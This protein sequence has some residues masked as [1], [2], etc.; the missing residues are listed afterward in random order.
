[1]YRALIVF[2]NYDLITELQ[3][4]PV[5]GAAT[6]FEINAV[7]RDGNS[8]YM[9]LR[10]SPYD[11]VIAEICLPN[12]DGLQ[13]LKKLT[14]EKLCSH[15]VLCSEYPNFDYARQGIIIGAF[16]YLV[17]PFKSELMLSLFNR[18]KNETYTNL[19]VEIYQS[20]EILEHFRGRNNELYTYLDKMLN[21]IYHENG[22]IVN[23][24]KMVRHIYDSVIDGLYE[25][26]EWMDLYVDQQSFYA[27][28]GIF[29]GDHSTY[30]R[31]YENKILKLFELYCELFP[32]VNNTQLEE[33]LVY[34]LNNPESDIRQKELAADMFMNT[35]Y[36]STVFSTLT[37][38]HFVD[39][40]QNV[41]LNRAAY[42]LENS[43]LKIAEIADRL[44]YKDTAYFSRLF[45]KKFAITPSEYKAVS[46]GADF[47]G[48]I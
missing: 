29:E 11:L 7:F 24:D 31:F 47:G 34:I 39:Y 35:S 25:E 40:L 9:E 26:N 33:I 1:M 12:M 2:D 14:R 15:V 45:K 5:W 16:D 38:S 48:H 42:L 6:E 37:G 27:I 17:R 4:L 22:D 21:G 41:R 44:N 46:S 28:D 3:A 20:D 32:N 18:I 23:A 8:A 10:K 13:L 30:R 19:S 36:F 43:P